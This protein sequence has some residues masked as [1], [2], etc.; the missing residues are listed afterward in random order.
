MKSEIS[1]RDQNV[2]QWTSQI[3]GAYVS[4]NEVAVQDLPDLMD[5]V[6]HKVRALSGCQGS[7][8]AQRPAVPIEASITPDHIICLEDGKKFKMLKKHLNT[9]YGLSP[10]EYRAKWGLPVD[11]PMVA[12]NYAMKRQ[13]LA[14]ASGLG[15][16]RPPV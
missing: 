1:M 11:Y 2:M 10:E 9:Q 13:Q 3:V 14:K 7:K 4:G 6:Y 5:L 16:S 12:P 8:A 15:K